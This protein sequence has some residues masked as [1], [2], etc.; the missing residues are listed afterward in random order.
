MGYEIHITR[1]EDWLDSENSP[2][3]LEEWVAFIEKN[4]DFRLDGYAETTSNQG[5]TIRV[6]NAGLA[7]WTAYSDHEE[8]KRMVWFNYCNGRIVVKNPDKEIIKRM[9]R[10]AR[11]FNAAVQGDDGEIYNEKGKSELSEQPG[12][13]KKKWWKFW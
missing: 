11:Y 2:I 13:Q 6:E 7:V 8:G 5:V 3:S 1:A 9:Y 4:D 12:N 10:V